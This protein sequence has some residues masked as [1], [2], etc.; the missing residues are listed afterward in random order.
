[1]RSKFGLK[2]EK[3]KPN[4]KKLTEKIIEMLCQIQAGQS[5]WKSPSSWLWQSPASRVEKSN[6]KNAKNNMGLK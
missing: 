3:V 4:E 1:M 2:F 6:I 5:L